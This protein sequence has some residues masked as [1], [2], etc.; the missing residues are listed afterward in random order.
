M[1]A[2]S[3]INGGL[4][5]DYDWNITLPWL[6][7]MGNQTL[8]TV[9]FANDTTSVVE[10]YSAT[11]S[12]PDASNAATVIYALYDN[13]LICR[14]GSLPGVGT[15]NPYTLF[16]VDINTSDLTFGQ[17]LW[18]N[19]VQPAAGNITVTLG[20]IDPTVGV[21]TEC[22]KET[23]QW[24]G[25]SMSTGKQLW[26][27]T[28]SQNALDYFGEPAPAQLGGE[29][30]YGNL[31]SGSMSGIT[32]C[33][34]MTT[35][36]LLWTYGNGG[37]GNSTYG[38]GYMPLGYYPTFIN[39]IGNGV[40]YLV[41]TEHTMEQPIIKFCLARAINAT[42]GQELWTISDYT[43]EFQIIPYA[44]ADG[45]TTFFNSYDQQVHTA[46]G[47]RGVIPT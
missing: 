47:K 9:T 20:P 43:G 36:N 34:S 12:N 45:Y 6:N 25:F 33:Y 2:N 8:S 5:T 28:S 7:V 40:V 42:T 37:E 24:V 18:W 23:M 31:Y 21:F 30:S 44:I 41:T 32:Y 27:P 29:C 1:T 16:A 15:Y 38:N 4:G 10:G 17:V 39:A 19:T 35:G 13:M 26:G 3:T 11:G 22:Y 14:N 46:Q